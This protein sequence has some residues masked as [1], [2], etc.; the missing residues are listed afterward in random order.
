MTI[1]GHINEAGDVF[2]EDYPFA[3]VDEGEL[4]AILG[5]GGYD[6]AMSHDPLP[7]A[8][9]RGGPP[10][11]GGRRMTEFE[12]HI[13]VPGGRLWAQWAGEGSAVV[14]VHAGI[15]DARMWDP[16]WDALVARHRVARYETRG[17]GRTETTDVPFSNRADLVAVLDAAGMDRA[18]F[19]GCSRA[20]QIV[21]DTA[22]E[23][24]ARCAGV[25][26]VCGGLSGFDWQETPDELAAFEREEALEE[27]RDWAALAD[28]DVQVWV[29]GIGQP[30]GRASAF[31]RDLV[32]T[33]S[34][35]TYVQEKE[36][37]QPIVLDPP[38]FD[39]LGEL[40]VPV[41]AIAG[42]LDNSSV[43]PA[44]GILVERAGARR[45]DLPDVAHMPSLERPEW[46]TETLLGFLAEVEAGQR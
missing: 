8:A 31:A 2:A 9:G 43:G 13:D 29:D 6:Q 3:D 16:Q 11:A 33:M 38:A 5:Q 41:L 44:A 28:H 7:A 37:G 19:V 18:V 34:Y 10:R 20:G 35:E 27:A 23:Y 26:W 21:V 15:A 42:G 12:G 32:R 1:A 14:L 36:T 24:P 22:L 4:V 25:A 40:R 46:F 39:R 30:A 45:I 17:F